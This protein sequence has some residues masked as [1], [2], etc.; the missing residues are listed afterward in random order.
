MC[1]GLRQIRLISEEDR[2]ARYCVEI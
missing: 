1:T 2:G